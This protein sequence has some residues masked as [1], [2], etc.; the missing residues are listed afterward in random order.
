M[1]IEVTQVSWALHAAQARHVRNPR[2][3][4]LQGLYDR[5]MFHV[6]IDMTF[7]GSIFRHV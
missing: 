1:S 4:K 3:V 2:A 6:G 5:D 7:Y